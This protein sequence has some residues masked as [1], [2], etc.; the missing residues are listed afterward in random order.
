MS[1]SMRAI[2]IRGAGG[3]DV[4]EMRVVPAPEPEVG[5][6]R[7]RVTAS[8]V[9]RADLLQRRGRYPAPP[10]YPTDIPGMEYSGVVEAVGRG[11]DSALEGSRVMGI[12]GGGAYAERVV[13]PAAT[14]VRVPANL[15]PVEAG[16]IPEV[17][18]TAFDA[19]FLQAG[20]GQGE[21]LLVHA[22][23]SGV[24][25]AALQLARR[26]GARTLGTSRTP[27]KLERAVELG[28]DV[29]VHAGAEEGW[30]DEV[31][32]ATAGRGAD[33]VLDLVGAPYLEGN[34]RVLAPSGRIMV[35]GTPAGARG[36]VD[37]GTL[38][39]KRATVRG[40]VLRARSTEEKAILAR[41]FERDVVPGFESGKL[42]PVVDR[43]YP[44]DEAAAAHAWMEENGNF[45]K[46]LLTW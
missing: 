35:V 17:F 14:L 12:T 43:I 46:I 2:V 8:G 41:A 34:L 45:G 37:L 10:G 18:M 16:A 39:R 38:M 42:R 20:L 31:L 22:V 30:P 21:T 24:G 25:T 44:A 27:A 32:E 5:E 13:V 28:L 33:V 11:A 3:P 4:L 1:E 6:V 26:A 19:V 7:V 9:N 29:P 23:G 40:T 15:E 36:A